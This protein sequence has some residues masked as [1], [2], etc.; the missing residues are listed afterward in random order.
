MKGVS[1]ERF[2]LSS[3][4]DHRSTFFDSFSAAARWN[5]IT[6]SDRIEL[7]MSGRLPLL[8]QTHNLP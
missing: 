5:A 7:L 4:T 2:C 6:I 3:L 1:E 8:Q